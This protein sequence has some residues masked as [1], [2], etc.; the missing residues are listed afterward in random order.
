[1]IHSIFN[2]SYNYEQ[3]YRKQQAFSLFK[4]LII[5]A[6]ESQVKSTLFQISIYP[7]SKVD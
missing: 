5:T 7:Y 1:M 6:H 2:I 3:G 4:V